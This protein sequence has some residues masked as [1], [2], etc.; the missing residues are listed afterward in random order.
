M[1][2]GLK[3]R[4]DEKVIICMANLRI[5][6]ELP[7]IWDHRLMADRKTLCPEAADPLYVIDVRAPQYNMRAVQCVGQGLFS[8]MDN[9]TGKTQ[10]EGQYITEFNFIH[11]STFFYML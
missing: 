11:D 2:S 6:Q 3:I 4:S 10:D 1:A 7:H 5:A 8:A 9:T